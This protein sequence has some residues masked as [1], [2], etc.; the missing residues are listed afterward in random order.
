MD[1]H[2]IVPVA[3]YV[4]E[5]KTSAVIV[6]TTKATGPPAVDAREIHQI[7]PSSK[8]EYTIRRDAGGIVYCQTVE[9]ACPAVTKQCPPANDATWR[10][11][12]AS[13]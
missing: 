1:Q 7:R 3:T 10:V 13:H 8:T 6:S 2:D 12:K 11:L 9:I 4:N 5:K